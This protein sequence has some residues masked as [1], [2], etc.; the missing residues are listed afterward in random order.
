LIFR[1]PQRR[2]ARPR[3]SGSRLHAPH[4][5]AK[6]GRKAAETAKAIGDATLESLIAFGL[7]K[8]PLE[9][10]R[11]YK[12]SHLTAVIEASGK[13]VFAGEAYD[14]L[15]TAGG[16]ARKQVVGAPPDRPYPQTNGW[17][18]W[19]FRNE[20]GQSQEIEAL[21]KGYIERAKQDRA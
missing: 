4:P 5:V 17:T 8:P 1:L 2:P 9:L 12:G 20:Q 3:A 15:S 21:R 7:I 13:V 11:D 14:S 18:F 6:P 16:M 19:H 10:E